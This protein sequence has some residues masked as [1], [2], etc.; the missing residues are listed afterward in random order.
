[1][2]PATGQT[3]AIQDFE[4]P[5]LDGVLVDVIHLRGFASDPKAEDDDAD[6]DAIVIG[7][8]RITLT[9]ITED[10]IDDIIG[11]DG[12]GSKFMIFMD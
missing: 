8:Q 11:H 12:R 1:M 7:G 2:R 6:A 3:D 5:G 9:G 4:L 10:Q